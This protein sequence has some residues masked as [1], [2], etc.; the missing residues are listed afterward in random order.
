[1]RFKRYPRPPYLT[2]LDF[3]RNPTCLS[4]Q[5]R[6]R[7]NRF[8]LPRRHLI[9]IDSH[10]I[11]AKTCNH[12]SNLAVAENNAMKTISSPDMHGRSSLL[13]YYSRARCCNH[14]HS[15]CLSKHLI[16]NINAY[17]RIGSYPARTILHLLHGLLPGLDEFILIVM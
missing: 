16:I 12:K 5:R 8:V 11:F 13:N 7:P 14:E 2:K 15:V 1:M 4:Q 6:L 10:H 9:T 3:R 17:Y